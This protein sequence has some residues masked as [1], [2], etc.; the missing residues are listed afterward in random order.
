MFV[1]YAINA[2]DLQ[3]SSSRITTSLTTEILSGPQLEYTAPCDDPVGGVKLQ[4][5]A[6]CWV[7]DREVMAAP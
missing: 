7:S 1:E 2:L 4:L 6:I 3:G 5:V